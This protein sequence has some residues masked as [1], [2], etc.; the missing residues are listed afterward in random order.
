MAYEAGYE[1]IDAVVG[2]AKGVAERIRLYERSVRRF[3]GHEE[4]V[5]LKAQV[6]DDLTDLRA[7]IERMDQLLANIPPWTSN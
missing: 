5:A 3:P 1:L 7:R 4:V 6:E 2:V